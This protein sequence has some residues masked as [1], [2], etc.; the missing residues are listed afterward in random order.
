MEATQTKKVMV[1]VTLTLNQEEVDWLMR[2]AQNC[3]TYLIEE[4][5]ADT[6]MRKEF[7]ETLREALK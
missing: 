2:F 4:T 1:T 3:P 6:A 7:Y 5:A